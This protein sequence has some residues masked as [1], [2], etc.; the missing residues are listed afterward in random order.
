[1]S[2]SGLDRR[3]LANDDGAVR[4]RHAPVRHAPV[5]HLALVAIAV[6]ALVVVS[7]LVLPGAVPPAG[8]QD[9]AQDD[10]TSTTSEPPESPGIIP[11]PNSGTEPDDAGDRGGSLQTVVFVVVV[12]GIVVIGGLVVRE[13][14]KARAQRGF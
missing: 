5:V 11:E 9:G 2:R 10:G 1:M 6:A 12:G 8:A 7:L 13:S 4:P 14:R 3:H